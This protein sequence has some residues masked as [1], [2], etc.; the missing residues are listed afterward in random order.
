[1]NDEVLLLLKVIS[2]EIRAVQAATPWESHIVPSSW[3]A[4][5]T[6]MAPRRRTRQW[7]RYW[8]RPWGSDALRIRRRTTWSTSIKAPSV[9]TRWTTATTGNSWWTEAFFPS[10]KVWRWTL[11]LVVWWDHS[12]SSAGCGPSPLNLAAPWSGWGPSMCSQ[13]SRGRSGGHVA[14]PTRTEFVVPIDQFWFWFICSPGTTNMFVINNHN[15]FSRVNLS[16]D[17]DFHFRKFD[18]PRAKDTDTALIPVQ[19]LNLHKNLILLQE[20]NLSGPV[21]SSYQLSWKK[22]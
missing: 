11:R 18:S 1:M 17:F 2:L 19:S 16:F 3:I 9:P 8:W 6:S 22:S 5:T 13:A 10:I 7:T 15:L 12:A 20:F 14:S 4:S 21:S